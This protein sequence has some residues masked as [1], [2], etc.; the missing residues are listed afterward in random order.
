MGNV[1]LVTAWR[2]VGILLAT[3]VEGL[4]LHERV[5][6]A[7]TVGSVVIFGGLA[8]SVMG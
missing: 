1:V 8:L 7:R 2:N 5:T 3:L 4:L 6:R